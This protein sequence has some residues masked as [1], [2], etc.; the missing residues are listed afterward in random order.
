MAF[1]LGRNVKVGLV[2]GLAALVM[3]GAMLGTAQ[4]QAGQP[5]RAGHE[6]KAEHGQRAEAFVQKVAVKLGTSEQ[7]LRDA[8]VAA[9]QEM[10]DE[11]VKAGRLTPEQAAKLKE[12][13]QQNGGR[14]F[15]PKI[16]A[17]VQQVARLRSMFASAAEQALGLSPDALRAERKAGN[18]LAEIARAQNKDPEAVEAQI[19]S[20]M[21]S[22]IDE[23]VA[24]GRLSAERATAL[25][26]RLEQLV[27][28]LMNHEPGQGQN[29]RAGGQRNTR[30]QG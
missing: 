21:R 30:P 16:R 9:Q 13:V 23:A 26:S 20:G 5:G 19:V 14:G 11:A 18:S 29:Q 27:D 2:G 6:R 10:I 15:A 7:N 28:R 4:A 25:K 1:V 17:G 12:R 3:G 22:R 8:L 24:A